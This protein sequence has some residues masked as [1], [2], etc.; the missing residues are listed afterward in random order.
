MDDPV[1]HDPQAVS[2]EAV[3]DGAYD[4][5]LEEYAEEDFLYQ[6][7]AF[8]QYWRQ[9]RLLNSMLISLLFILLLFWVLWDII[10]FAAQGGE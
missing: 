9:N 4:T 8:Q 3:V 7:N 6:E 5:S 2:A 1:E 10:I